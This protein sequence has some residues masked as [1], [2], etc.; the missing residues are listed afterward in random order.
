MEPL[1]YFRKEFGFLK[2]NSMDYSFIGANNIALI[3]LLKEAKHGKCRPSH[4][5]AFL[6]I[7]TALDVYKLCLLL[8]SSK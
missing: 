6:D 7:H 4:K 8:A 1:F 2:T 3:L 5:Q